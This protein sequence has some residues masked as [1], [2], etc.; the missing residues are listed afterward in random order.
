M[1]KKEESPWVSYLYYRYIF[2]YLTTYSKMRSN[3]NDIEKIIV[4]QRVSFILATGI[5]VY[6]SMSII[7]RL[8]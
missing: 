5:C 7:L 1:K 6:H 2:D 8:E 4:K 3:D